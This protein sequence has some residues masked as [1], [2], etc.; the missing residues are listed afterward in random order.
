MNIGLYLDQL[1]NLIDQM[2]W[3]DEGDRLKSYGAI[4]VLCEELLDYALYRGL[5]HELI[6]KKVH[7]FTWSARSIAGL[8]DGDY[9]ATREHVNA[10]FCALSTMKEASCFGRV[11]NEPG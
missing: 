7:E 6:T 10:C 1:E 4:R 9:Q 5:H 3:E 8:S 2:Q 11:L